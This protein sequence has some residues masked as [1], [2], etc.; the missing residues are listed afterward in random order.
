V[1]CDSEQAAYLKSAY[2]RYQPLLLTPHTAVLQRRK[3]F[4][5]LLKNLYIR[6]RKM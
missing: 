6:N 3:K 2:E 1:D 5:R 4:L